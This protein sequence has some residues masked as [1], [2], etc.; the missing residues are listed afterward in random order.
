MR[1]KTPFPAMGALNA[2]GKCTSYSYIN[3]ALIQYNDGY[4]GSPRRAPLP[5]HDRVRDLGVT[6]S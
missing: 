3:V 5:G 2:A 1:I 6:I 4:V